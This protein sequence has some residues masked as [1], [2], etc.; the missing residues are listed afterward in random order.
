MYVVAY[1]TIDGEVSLA[2]IDVLNG[3]K[4]PLIEGTEV[5]EPE[6]PETEAK[7]IAPFNVCAAE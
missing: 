4:A 2:N 3:A 7:I 1:V 5:D 6:T